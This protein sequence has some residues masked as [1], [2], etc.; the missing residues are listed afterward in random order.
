MALLDT[1]IIQTSK[2]EL[3]TELFAHASSVEL[4]PFAVTPLRV[5]SPSCIIIW[6]GISITVGTF[7]RQL[8]QAPGP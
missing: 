2:N 4:Q 7:T 1:R 5:H 8:P 6:D 3:S